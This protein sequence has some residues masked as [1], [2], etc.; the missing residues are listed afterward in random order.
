MIMWNWE[1]E[2]ALES[3]FCHGGRSPV[4]D[5][6]IGYRKRFTGVLKI[7][8]WIIFQESKIFQEIVDPKQILAK[9][10]IFQEL[11][12]SFEIFSTGVL[13]IFQ[14]IIFQ[15]WKIFQENFD[16]KQILAKAKIFQERLW[17]PH[18]SHLFSLNGVLTDE[19]V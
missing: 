2:V 4:D 19:S 9:A 13:K 12:S 16:P 7:F 11:F 18:K 1:C 15:E 14:W 10:K 8:Q 17:R 3:P 5:F 6:S